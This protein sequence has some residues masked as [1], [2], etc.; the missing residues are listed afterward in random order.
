MPY[1]HKD[2]HT[3][4]KSPIYWKTIYQIYNH[5]YLQGEELVEVRGGKRGLKRL[6]YFLLHMLLNCRFEFLQR[7]CTQC[8]ACIH[9]FKTLN[10]PQE[11][12]KC[13]EPR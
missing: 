12:N 5:S 3:H 1:T 9:K 8:A 7:T 10:K 13:A 6:F 11:L 4:K 2:R